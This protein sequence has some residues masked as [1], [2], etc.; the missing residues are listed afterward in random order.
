M[1]CF[2]FSRNSVNVG[3]KSLLTLATPL[4]TKAYTDINDEGAIAVAMDYLKYHDPENASR[5]DAISLLA[6]MQ[7][8]ADGVASTMS[9][10]DF[11][12]YFEEYKTQRDNS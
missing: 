1:R 10:E 6:F 7:T 11:D 8:V 12:K 9:I 5:E 4:I 3:C 2:L